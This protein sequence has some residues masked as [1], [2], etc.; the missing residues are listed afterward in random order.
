MKNKNIIPPVDIKLIEKELNDS[1]FVRK[2]NKVDNEIYIVNY[3]N[4]PNVVKEIGRLREFT[5]TEAGGGTGKELDLDNLDVSENCY[6]QL[7]VYDREDK[8]IV[9]GYRFIDCSSVLNGDSD[10]IPLSTRH[11]FNFSKKFIRQYLPYTIELGRSWVHPDY[12]SG[13][14]KKGLFALDNLWDGLGAIILGN[15]KMKYFFGKVTMYSSY[16]VEARN[17]LLYFMNAYFPDIENLVTPIHPISIDHDP[18]EIRELIRNKNFNDGLK[19]LNQYLKTYGEFIPPLINIYMKLSPTM[20]SFG[21]AL[22]PDF[23]GVEETGILVTVDDIYE[24]KKE[25]HLTIK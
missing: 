10:D 3:H 19:S 2:T 17:A 14:S 24:E 23:G 20:K 7:I 1:T 15:P 11:Y 22:N 16:N 12:Q 25:R 4:S 13:K 9:G 6:E 18:T 21:T 5:F 8:V